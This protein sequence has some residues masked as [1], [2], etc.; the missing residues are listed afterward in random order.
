MMLRH[1]QF[2]NQADRIHNAILQTISEGKFRTADLG[3]KASTSDFTKAV[4]D[5]IWSSDVIPSSWLFS[6]PLIF[7]AYAERS[8]SFKRLTGGT[9]ISLGFSMG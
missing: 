6:F 2:N 9:S 7:V 1:L 5:H 3:G 8:F 4:C